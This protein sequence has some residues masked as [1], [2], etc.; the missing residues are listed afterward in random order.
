MKIE[1]ITKEEFKDWYTSKVTKLVLDQL[2]TLREELKEYIGNGGTLRKDSV[3]STEYA[4]G[5]IQG[6]NDVLGIQFEEPKEG[7]KYGH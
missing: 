7:T 4:V 1:E 3:I 2:R 5:R 6:L